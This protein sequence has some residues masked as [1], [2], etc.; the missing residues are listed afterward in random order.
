M[1]CDL[2]DEVKIL[3]PTGSLTS[4]SANTIKV[5]FKSS[6]RVCKQFPVTCLVYAIRELKQIHGSPAEICVTINVE[7]DHSDLCVSGFNCPY[8]DAY[9]TSS[10][11]LC[12]IANN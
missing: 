5:S 8:R 3:T 10:L 2:P 9:F 4:N 6:A 11:G 7:A 1:T 12:L